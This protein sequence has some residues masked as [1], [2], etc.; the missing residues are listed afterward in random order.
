MDDLNKQQV[1]A[2][3]VAGEYCVKLI[4][5]IENAVKEF[6][7]NKLPD[8]DEYLNNILL[9]L[10]WLFEVYGKTKDYIENSGIEIDKN[11][12]NGSVVILNEAIRNNDDANKAIAL[13]GEILGFVKLMKKVADNIH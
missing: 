12:V 6:E 8:S 3:E 1:E 4:S 2:L 9:G 11:G 10:N 7:G 13:K 5:G